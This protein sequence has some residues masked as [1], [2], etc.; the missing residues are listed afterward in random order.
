MC[1]QMLDGL[2]CLQVRRVVHNDV[3][4]ENMLRPRRA[5]GQLLAS[6]VLS[7]LGGAKVADRNGDVPWT[8]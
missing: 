1:P 6:L 5:A 4:P 7:D 2:A 8:K 3:K